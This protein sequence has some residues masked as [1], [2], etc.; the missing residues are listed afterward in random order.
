MSKFILALLAGL[1]MA[2]PASAATVPVNSLVPPFQATNSSVRITPQGVNYGVYADAARTGGSLEYD[3]LNGTALSAITN[4][5]FVY[6]YNTSDENPIAAPYM[7]IFFTA[8]GVDQDIILD[9]TV[10][11]T[12]A[13]PENVDNTISAPPTTVR[14]NDDACTDVANQI[15]L[16]EAIAAAGPGAVITGIF[17]TQ[18]FSGGTDASAYVRSMTVNANTF[19]FDVPPPAGANGANGAPG[20]TTVVQ[21]PVAVPV[22]ARPVGQ[23]VVP[24]CNGDDVRTIHAPSLK[25][26]KF[27]S[28]RASL[29]GKKL[30]VSGRTIRVDL[31]ERTEGNYNV[32]I[33]TRYR[34]STTGRTFTRRNT[35]PL[36][37]ACA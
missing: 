14:L 21:V 10:C 4:I 15:T 22:A 12:V 17:I 8:G 36:S 7:R 33:T 28:A 13:P 31:R 6:N 24:N 25:G 1:L 27:V 37:V 5:G 23:A 29:R 30:N 32:R 19:R 35:R 3:G 34:S 9:P 2:A 16:A 18:G 20:V 26:A 11:A